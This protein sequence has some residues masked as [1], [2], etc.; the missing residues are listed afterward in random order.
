MRSI[1]HTSV[2]S[3]SG[4]ISFNIIPPDD[5]DRASRHSSISFDRRSG[6]S[7][8][9]T[10]DNP[11]S[12]QIFEVEPGPGGSQ[13]SL[14]RPA[15]PSLADGI[16]HP[17]IY[18]LMPYKLP[19]YQRERWIEES[20]I[21]CSI[22]AT[23]KQYSLGELPDVKGKKGIAVHSRCLTRCRQRIVTD[24]WI[25]DE[26]MFNLLDGFIFTIEDYTRSK[27]LDQPP[28]TLLVLEIIV[29]DGVNWCGYYYACST[30]KSVFWLDEIDISVHAGEVRGKISPTHI[31]L[32]LEHQYWFHWDLFPQVNDATD[33]IYDLVLNA[34]T[35]ART[36]VQSSASTTVNYTTDELI[37]MTAIVEGM[38]GRLMASHWCIGR[39]MQRLVKDRFLNYYGQYGARLDYKQS[40]H[41]K[42][43]PRR[44]LLIR[45][46]S[47]LLLS[48]PNA[49]L[50]DLQSL[51]VD[52]M[53]LKARWVKFFIKMNQQWGEHIVHAS[54]LLNAN[55]AFLAI[56]SNDPSN[57][58]SILLPHRTIAQIASY[59]SV[60]TSFGSMM[61]ALMLV[62]QHKTKE[63]ATLL[64]GQYH[65]FLHA[66][67][68]SKYGFEGLAIVYSLPYALL[69]WAM[70]SFFAA[71]VM[72]CFV[73]STTLVRS[74]LGVVGGLLCA[75]ILGCIVTFWEE[76]GLRVR[77]H[78]RK[79]HPYLEKVG[80]PR[81]ATDCW[82]WDEKLFN[83]LDGF[84]R[85]IE[86]HT[87]S[88]HLDQPLD[89]LLVLEISVEED[90]DLN[91][92][93]YY[94]ACS[95]TKS[96]FWLDEMDITVHAG[97]AR[98]DLSPT[99]IR[100]SSD[101]LTLVSG[102]LYA[103]LEYV[104]HEVHDPASCIT[105]P[106]QVKDRFLNYHGQYGARLNFGQSVHG[107]RKDPRRTLLIRMFSPLLLSAPNTHLKS[108]QSLWVDKMTIKARWVKYFIKLNEQWGE[109]IVH[110][111]ILL[112]AN[113]AFLA[114]PSND[115]SNNSSVLLPHR[116]IAQIASY[117]SVVTSFGSMM[118]ALM[119]VRQH[120][121]KESPTHSVGQYESGLKVREHLKKLH[122]YL[123]KFGRPVHTTWMRILRREV[124]EP[125]VSK[126][127]LMEERR[128]EA[129]VQAMDAT[130]RQHTGQ[131]P[132]SR[133]AHSWP[134][135]WLRRNHT[136]FGG[137]KPVLPMDMP[138]DS[139]P[140]TV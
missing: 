102:A 87:E 69:T 71:F 67:Y 134:Y 81:I 103:A 95:T 14:V 17:E 115:P 139:P 37:E 43:S 135:F 57:N 59:V 112:N 3:N 15:S 93:G 53:T 30:T 42:K 133:G 99:H 131:T 31:Q 107:E 51:W 114:I 88:K 6:N 84:L 125:V 8:T 48:A 12:S 126:D 137:S 136:S 90:L 10:T 20:F 52:K 124:K 82:I 56:P 19:R 45:V 96:V 62:R 138:I 116:T 129:D 7:M 38:K 128:K 100:E 39:F 101:E 86:A 64:V 27:N 91:W 21:D 66:H 35:D 41:A 110:A 54:I 72:M 32:Y 97:E 118:L 119:L 80:R 9:V 58:S 117:I 24:C 11:M 104:H 29:E 108:L 61:L 92:C 5:D 40:I 77:E 120:K 18:P 23:R 28:D 140:S 13:R 132:N 33:R 36:D 4:G 16:P 26:E 73:I 74:I 94:Y 25:W 65:E 78:L 60:L 49:H 47:P 46:L 85:K 44:T 76:S 105:N 121:A 2:V 83:L 130:S 55:V 50:N 98:G 63:S 111:S 79:L 22:E 123:E 109:H 70:I 113:V 127:D 1:S 89:T 34:L 106:S 68:H 75:L 122:P